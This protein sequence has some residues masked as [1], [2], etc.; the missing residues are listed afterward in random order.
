MLFWLFFFFHVFYLGLHYLFQRSGLIKSV[1]M[2]KIIFNKNILYYGAFF[3]FSKLNSRAGQ[4]IFS[5][6]W[7]GRNFKMIFY[8][9]GCLI[10]I[11]HSFYLIFSCVSLWLF[12]KQF[13]RT[14]NYNTE[15][16]SHST[17]L[18]LFNVNWNNEQFIYFLNSNQRCFKFH[19][20]WHDFLVLLTLS[21]ACITS[22]VLWSPVLSSPSRYWL[23]NIS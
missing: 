13:N 19:M 3:S 10:Y 7:Q 5:K 2:R 20:I 23:Y 18:F 15:A 6:Y 21:I 14:N 12:W 1:R 4:E 17:F 16:P 9:H 8:F 22:T 11:W